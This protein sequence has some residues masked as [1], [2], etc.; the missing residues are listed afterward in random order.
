MTVEPK[1]IPIT[2][3]ALD[4]D[5][6]TLVE[7]DSKL[8]ISTI[9]PSNATNKNVIW[10]TSNDSI[11]SVD[12]NG[13]VIANSAGNATITVTTEQ[14]NIPATC[15]VIV[16]PKIIPVTSILLNFSSLELI[17]GDSKILISHCPSSQCN[18]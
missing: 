11:A 18:K 15:E 8:L 3:I 16:E 14:G 7:G 5:T 12:Q 9:E 1:T 10:K 6:L 4:F 13:K 2:S 17:E